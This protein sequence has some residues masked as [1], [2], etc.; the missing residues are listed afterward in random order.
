MEIVSVKLVVFKHP[1]PARWDTYASYCHATRNFCAYG[2]SAS[3][4]VDKF[5]S[6]LIRDLQNRLAYVNM[7]NYGWEVS[8]NSAKPPIFTYEYLVSDTEEPKKQYELPSD[9]IE[10]FLS[11]HGFVVK[12]IAYFYGHTK[13]VNEGTKQYVK[14]PTK[15]LLTKM[16]IEKCLIDAGLSFA[17]LD[18][19]IEHLKAVKLFDSIMEESLNRSSKKD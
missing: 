16:Q 13:F 18:A 8:E 5:K 10:E 11:V 6:M 19:Y 14:V 4:V 9:L 1:E 3:E 15:K 7:K 2:K 12:E 17:D